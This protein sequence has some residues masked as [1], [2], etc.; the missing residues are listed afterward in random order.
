MYCCVYQHF[1]VFNVHVRSRCW[2]GEASCFTPCFHPAAKLANWCIVASSRLWRI[3]TMHDTSCLVCWLAL[4]CRKRCLKLQSSAASR[5]A[6]KQCACTHLSGVHIS[7]KCASTKGIGGCPH[8][9]I[10][11]P[12]SPIRRILQICY[13]GCCGERGGSPR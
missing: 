11:L 9:E 7:W 8:Q 1:S 6:Q 2:R 3:C 4:A 12:A 10:D 13:C 5:L